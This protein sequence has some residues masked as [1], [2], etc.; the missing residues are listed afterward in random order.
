MN[1]RRPIFQGIF[2]RVSFKFTGCFFP[3]KSNSIKNK[4]NKR[5]KKRKTKKVLVS[6]SRVRL[7]YVAV[8]IISA[9]W[10]RIRRNTTIS[11]RS[12][13]FKHHSH[14]QE[15]CSKWFKLKKTKKKHCVHLKLCKMKRK[16]NF[17]QYFGLCENYQVFLMCH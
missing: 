4:S 11:E 17:Q 10:I 15:I 9:D 2:L 14:C 13:M 6:V 1:K 8:P 7:I 12:S 16:K 3:L 5:R